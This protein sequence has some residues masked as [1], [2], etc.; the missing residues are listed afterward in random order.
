MVNIKF[1]GIQDNHDPTSE[2]SLS[3][4][5]VPADPP[6]RLVYTVRDMEQ[7][8]LLTDPARLE[9]VRAFAERPRTTKQVADLLEVP[10]TRLYRHVDAL[11]EAGLLELIAERPKRGTVE[12]YLRAVARRFEVDP[13]LFAQTDGESAD[14]GAIL[15]GVE[16]DVSRA[17]ADATASSDPPLV[18]HAQFVGSPARVARFRE[19]LT[20]LLDDLD[21]DAGGDAGEG[22]VVYGWLIALYPKS[23]DTS[24][25]EP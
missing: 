7:V 17:L 4:K 10:P 23:R 11:L 20:Q 6:S 12:R 22:D 9:L 1:E 21:E 18:A 2:P 3:R 19:K 16:Q 14:F 8:R 25:P 5:P 24:A 13:A 15:R